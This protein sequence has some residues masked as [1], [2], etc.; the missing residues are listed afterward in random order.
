MDRIELDTQSLKEY[1]GFS[2]MRNEEVQLQKTRVFSN[3]IEKCKPANTLI[4]TSIQKMSNINKEE[5]LKQR[6]SR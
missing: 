5:G 3:K 2:Q 4:V 6:I 1:R